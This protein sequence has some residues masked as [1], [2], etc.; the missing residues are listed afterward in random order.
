MILRN[1]TIKYKGYD[2]LTL[3]KGSHK[4]ICVSC[5]IC[6]RIR[7]VNYQDYRSL[8]VKCTNKG[9]RS[10]R[11]GKHHSEETKK[12]MSEAHKGLKFNDKHKLKIS[13]SGKGRIVSEKTRNKIRDSLKGKYVGELGANWKGGF[14]I[15]RPYLS[16]ESKCIKLNSRF[17]NSEFHHIMKSVG[18]YIPKDIHRSIYHNI[19][20]CQGMNEINKL[21]MDY[22]VGDY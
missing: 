21:V 5:D 15:L 8:C 16:T 18:I 22:L 7:Y 13:K 19:K 20:T 11:Y 2:P 14:N 3:S 12:K 1:A 9:K 6:G 17:N 10:P 4:R